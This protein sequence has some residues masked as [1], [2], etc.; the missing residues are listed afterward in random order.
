LG[1]AAGDLALAH[2]SSA[3]V[4]AS[5][6]SLRMADL[7]KSPLFGGRFIAKGRYRSWMERIPVFLARHP[8]PGLL[9]AAIAF[10]R[11]VPS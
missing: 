1:S 10:E 2:G 4:I 7:I 9:G 11:A 6:L 5:G 3:V 8:E